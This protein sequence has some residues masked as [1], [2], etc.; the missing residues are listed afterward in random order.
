MP[1]LG[2]DR[3]VEVKCRADGFAQIYKWVDGNYALVVKRDRG[4]PLVVM[5]RRDALEVAKVAEGKA[6]EAVL[7]PLPK[8]GAGSTAN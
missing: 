7:V 2:T 4:E 8:E 5:Q 1:L 6:A 3:K